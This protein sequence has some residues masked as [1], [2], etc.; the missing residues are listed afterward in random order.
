MKFGR[1]IEPEVKFLGEFYNKIKHAG[2]KM[3]FVI[4][5]GVSGAGKH[6]LKMLEDAEI[7]FVWTIFLFHWWRNLL[8]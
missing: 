6:C 3:R 7:I 4:V 8:H 1:D 5:T 2:D